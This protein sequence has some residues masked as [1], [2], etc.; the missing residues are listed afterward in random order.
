MAEKIGA[1][2]NSSF[3]AVSTAPDFCKTPVG[4]S[5][6]PLP[7][8]ITSDLEKSVLFVPSVKFNTCPSYVLDQSIVPTCTGDEPGSATGVKSGTVGDKTVPTGAS[9]TV[10]AGKKRIVRELDTCTMNNGNTTG[11]YV[12]QSAPGSGIGS[13]GKPTANTDPPGFFK[14]LKDAAKKS[15]EDVKG[16]ASTLWDASG[17]S[18]AS[19]GEAS[20]ARG[21]IW[22]GAKGVASLAKDVT[23]AQNFPGTP[24]GQEAMGRLSDT[25][26]AVLED[27]KQTYKQS[28]AEGGLSQAAGTG[29]WAVVNLAIQALT[30]KGAG[31]AVAALR[32]AKTMGG[33]AEAFKLASKE[34]RTLKLAKGEIAALEK[35]AVIAEKKAVEEGG[36]KV[37]KEGIEKTAKEAVEKAAAKD[38]VKIKT[39]EKKPKKIPKPRKPNEKKWRKKGGTIKQNRDGSVTYTNKNG[40]SVTYNKDG[41]PDFGPHEK[42]RVEIENMKGDKTDFTKA[43][44]AYRNKIGDQSWKKPDD[45]TWHHNQDGKTMQ[46]VN[47]ELHEEF[48]HTGG[49]SISRNAAK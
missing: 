7:Y 40:Q 23:V 41:Y 38:G 16:D 27:I 24:M 13:G 48:Q 15:W 22:E 2:K 43:D 9:S 33:M 37:A 4:A 8:Q 45:M 14:G 32:G 47:S 31:E 44:K 30:T 21:R 49:A 46:L 39:L 10:R 12:T 1:R 17:L 18:S 20:A 29:T 28:Y 5:T 26:K 25:G 42:G 36:G 19:S 6:P 11:I 35:V 34:A 3:K